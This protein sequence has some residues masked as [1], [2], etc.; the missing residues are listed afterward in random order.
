M[1][2]VAVTTDITRMTYLLY[3]LITIYF[4]ILFLKNTVAQAVYYTDSKSTPIREVNM[5]EIDNTGYGSKG[6]I[7]TFNVNIHGMNFSKL[8]ITSSGVVHMVDTFTD[9]SPMR[10]FR[11]VD[12]RPS[13]SHIFT[14]SNSEAYSITWLKLKYCNSTSKAVATIE[15]LIYQDSVIQYE[16]LQVL[17][18]TENCNITI[19]VTDGTYNSRSNR[20][21]ILGNVIHRVVYESSSLLNRTVFTLSPVRAPT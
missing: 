6:D 11:I 9:G 10:T 2:F 18:G 20:M 14:L 13:Y 19:E 5:M 16:L 17:G 7:M 8:N 12:A 3:Y 4:N 21:N 15:M 1:M